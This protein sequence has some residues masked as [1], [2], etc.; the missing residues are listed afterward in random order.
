M[1]YFYVNLASIKIET[2]MTISDQVDITDID[3]FISID[4]L[5]EEEQDQIRMY[6]NPFISLL[7]N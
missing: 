2:D 6:L 5:T 1:S 3:D 4:S 7:Q